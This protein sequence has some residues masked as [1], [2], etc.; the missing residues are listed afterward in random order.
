MTFMNYYLNW[1]LMG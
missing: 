1:I